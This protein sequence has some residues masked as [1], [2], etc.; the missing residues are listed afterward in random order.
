MDLRERV[1][2]LAKLLSSQVYFS[3]F[4]CYFLFIYFYSVNNLFFCLVIFLFI[5]YE[6]NRL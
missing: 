6:K 5:F 1:S 4:F 3:L 2:K